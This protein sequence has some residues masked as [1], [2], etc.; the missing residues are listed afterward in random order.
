ML[1][2]LVTVFLSNADSQIL[3]STHSLVII[4]KT[5]Q[6]QNICFNAGHVENITHLK[7]LYTYVVPDY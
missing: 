1:S 3:D 7:T 2:C 6:P 5:S 4:D